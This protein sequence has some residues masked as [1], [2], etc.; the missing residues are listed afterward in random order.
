[1]L[2]DNQQKI[3][4]HHSLAFPSFYSAILDILNGGICL[5]RLRLSAKYYWS[6]FIYIYSTQICDK[7]DIFGKHF[8][9]GYNKFLEFEIVPRM[10]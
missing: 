10:N 4:S 3:Q 9:T 6:L 1:M 5:K 7:K 8:T 2:A